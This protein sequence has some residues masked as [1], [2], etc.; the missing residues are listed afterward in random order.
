MNKEKLKTKMYY[1]ISLGAICVILILITY[2]FFIRTIEVDVMEGL[3]I[4]YTKENG[5]ASANAT[6]ESIDI[7]Q[8]TQNFMQTVTYTITPNENLSNGDV[9]HIV[10][11]YDETLASQ[12]HFKPVNVEKDIV[13]EGLHNRFASLS[14]IEIDYIQSIL[15]E[16]DRYINDNSDSI[17]EINEQ[18]EEGKLIENKRVYQ[19]FLKSNSAKSSDRVLVIYQLLYEYEKEMI[20]LYYTVSVPEINDGNEV[21]TQDIFGEKAYLSENELYHL[22]F[23]S[24]IQR[25][26]G[27]QYSI[28]E[29]KLEE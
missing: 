29:I 9:I 21:D 23:S 1:F 11:S 17:F 10:A 25:V 16:S 24:Y 14:D 3:N 4:E 2:M 18:K 22:D 28:E 20:T 26:Y 7:N 19:V 13:V 5:L 27:S 8:R 6:N 12:Y 15:K